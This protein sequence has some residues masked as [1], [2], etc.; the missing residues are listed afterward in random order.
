MIHIATHTDIP[1]YSFLPTEQYVV[2]S[3]SIS[4]AKCPPT[5]GF[6]RAEI[7]SSGFII[8]A[9]DEERSVNM[10][11]CVYVCIYLTCV[12]MIGIYPLRISMLPTCLYGMHLPVQ[13]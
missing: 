13:V 7:L 12:D 6:T 11:V 1:I 8:R 2:S 4:Y 3:R 10:Y 9:L 5:E